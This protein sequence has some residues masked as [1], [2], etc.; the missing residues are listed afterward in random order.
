MIQTDLKESV[1]KLLDEVKRIIDS[2]SF[3]IESNFEFKR[4]R[5]NDDPLDPCNNNNTLLDLN[6]DV[7]DVVNEVYSLKIQHFY[8]Y[9]QD[10]KKGRHK[11]FYEFIKEINGRQVYIKLKINEINSEKILC[12]SFHYAKRKVEKNDLPFVDC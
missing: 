3:D 12:V 9:M 1:Q 7:Q 11:P 8:K 6:Y 5:L 4:N 2:D 10:N